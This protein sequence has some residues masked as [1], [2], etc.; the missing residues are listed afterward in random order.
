MLKNAHLRSTAIVSVMV[1][2]AALILNVKQ[3]SAI[4]QYME[5]KVVV[6]KKIVL[7]LYS[8]GLEGAQGFSVIMDSSVNKRHAHRE[9]VR[10]RLLA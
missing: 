3:I 5:V 7:H 6:V 10:I 8:A 4:V 1:S 9:P 2:N